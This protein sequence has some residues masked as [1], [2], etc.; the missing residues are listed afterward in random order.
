[1]QKRRLLSYPWRDN[2]MHWTLVT[3]AAQGLGREVCLAL[4]EQKRAVLIHYNQSADGALSLKNRCQEQGAAAEIIQGDFSTQEGVADFIRR[5]SE[6]YPTIRA[7]VN[8]VGNFFAKAVLETS[9]EE[10]LALFQTN[11]YAPFALIRALAASLIQEK[12][13]IVNLGMAG[14]NAG[15]ADAYC[16]V[17]SMTK[18]A[19]FLLT[20]SLAKEL[21]PLGVNVNM[22]SPGYMENT[23]NF[24]ADLSKIPLGRFSELQ[25]V[26]RVVLFLLDPCNASIT[27]QNIEVA[28]GVRL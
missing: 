20:K 1:M 21:A 9:S 11:L 7:L 18:G 27:G 22:V 26:A 2:R 8:N 19:L 5:L 12:G 28:G 23:N 16:P 4:A 3:G 24:P 17:Y 10:V 13:A 25:E 6:N 15:G 14:L